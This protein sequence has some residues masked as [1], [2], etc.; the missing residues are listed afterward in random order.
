MMVEPGPEATLKPVRAVAKRGAQRAAMYR[1]IRL[2]PVDAKSQFTREQI[3]E[4]VKSALAD[5]LRSTS[6]LLE[7]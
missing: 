5:Y 6:G 1:G 3:H 7:P 4:A 2:Q